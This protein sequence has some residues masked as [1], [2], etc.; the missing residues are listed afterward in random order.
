MLATSMTNQVSSSLPVSYFLILYVCIESS[1]M[2]CAGH[3][4]L[5]KWLLLSDPDDSGSEAKGYLKVSIIILGTGDEP[6]V[7]R[8]I[9]LPETKMH[10]G[11]TENAI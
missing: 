6:P 4:I 11:L 9:P 10:F 1:L 7:S 2:S 5:R 3:A 8:Q